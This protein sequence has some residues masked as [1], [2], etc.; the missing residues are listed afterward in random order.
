MGDGTITNAMLEQLTEIIEKCPTNKLVGHWWLNLVTVHQ[1]CG[2]EAGD[3]I[4]DAALN[5]FLA[6][7][8]LGTV[9][10]SIAFMGALFEAP[11]LRSSDVS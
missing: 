6:W 4:R 8:I 7:G 3:K 10:T 2:R 1:S 5:Y 11:M 9:L